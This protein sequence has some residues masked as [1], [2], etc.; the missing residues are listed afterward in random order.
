MTMILT[1]ILTTMVNVSIFNI[2]QPAEEI[3]EYL[4]RGG[5]CWSWVARVDD[6]GMRRVSKVHKNICPDPMIGHTVKDRAVLKARLK[7]R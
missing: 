3:K 1:A 7:H 5:K 4:N 6:E 2:P